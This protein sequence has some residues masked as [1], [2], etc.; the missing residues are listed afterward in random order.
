MDTSPTC[1]ADSVDD[2]RRRGVCVND[3]GT[4]QEA[5]DDTRQT[6]A[7]RHGRGWSVEE[8]SALREGVAQ[9][10]VGSWH[11]IQTSQPALSLRTAAQ[12]GDKWRN[13]A[14]QRRRTDLPPR[15]FALL[16]EDHTLFRIRGRPIVFGKAAGGKGIGRVRLPR[17]AALRAASRPEIYANGEVTCRIYIREIVQKC[18]G[19]SEP[20]AARKTKRTTVYVYEGSRSRMVPPPNAGKI[21]QRGIA[22]RP[23]VHFVRKEPLRVGRFAV[24]SLNPSRTTANSIEQGILTVACATSD[25]QGR[26][27]SS[28]ALIR[29]RLLRRLQATSAPVPLFR[30][31]VVG[32]EIVAASVAGDGPCV[33]GTTV[34]IGNMSGGNSGD[35]NAVDGLAAHAPVSASNVHMHAVADPLYE[36]GEGWEGAFEAEDE[37]DVDGNFI[38]DDGDDHDEY[39]DDDAV[40]D[41]DED[42]GALAA[43]FMH[44]G[45][46]VDILFA[47]D[48]PFFLEGED[49]D[50]GETHKSDSG[51]QLQSAS[52]DTLCN[53]SL[54]DHAFGRGH[55]H[56]RARLRRTSLARYL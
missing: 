18:R 30:D 41:E 35:L 43:A 19:A 51:E 55:R 48:D 25:T 2:I 49:E 6:R 45:D 17:D 24:Q 14:L 44:G 21:A 27:P 26:S 20:P 23:S 47:T 38:G 34:A 50:D 40:E 15:K 8:I 11:V 37:F 7:A 28:S 5:S 10:G 1:E 4:Q 3:V 42:E 46:D 53:S 29:E 54:G 16:R 52:A 32:H 22:W 36:G 33:R 31:S 12:L 9:H 56:V 13:I 39:E